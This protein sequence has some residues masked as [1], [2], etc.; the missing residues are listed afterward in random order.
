MADPEHLAEQLSAFG[1]DPAAV[2]AA[3]EEE[4]EAM[5]FEIHPDNLEALNAFLAMQT[6]WRVAVGMAGAFYVGLEYAAIPA[7]LALL[8][9]PRAARAD[10]FASLRAME[11]AALRVLNS[12]R[13]A[14]G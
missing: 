13:P 8:G 7:V 6:Q 2:E 14:D 5:L 9:I 3:R 11:S 1:F 12:P 4:T 10:I